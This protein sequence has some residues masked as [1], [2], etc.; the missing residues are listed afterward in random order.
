MAKITKNA[1]TSKQVC[2][3]RANNSLKTVK[4][5]VSWGAM[6]NSLAEP[7]AAPVLDVRMSLPTAPQLRAWSLPGV[8]F[9]GTCSSAGRT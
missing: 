9:T 2:V 8:D 4:A 6:A 5:A 7:V 3:K 1:K